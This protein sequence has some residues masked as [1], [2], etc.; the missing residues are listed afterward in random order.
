M[1]KHEPPCWPSRHGISIPVLIGLLVVIRSS[2]DV[3]VVGVGATWPGVFRWVQYKGRSPPN[4]SI[5]GRADSS[6]LLVT[7]PRGGLTSCFVGNAGG[8]KGPPLRGC[9]R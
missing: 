6:F 8:A 5:R 3:F 1:A 4:A 2:G 7:P 9:A